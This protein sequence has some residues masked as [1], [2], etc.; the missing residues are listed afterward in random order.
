MLPH[1][2]ATRGV[3]MSNLINP[4]KALKF[5]KTQAI[6]LPSTRKLSAWQAYV[7]ESIKESHMKISASLAKDFKDLPPEKK[8]VMSY[9]QFISS[10]MKS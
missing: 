3:T 5:L 6:K 1:W 9:S 8:K 7:T 10:I 2:K 4:Q